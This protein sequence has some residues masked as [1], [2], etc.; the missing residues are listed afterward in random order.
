MSSEELLSFTVRPDRDALILKVSGDAD[1]G[2]A[3]RLDAALQALC[4]GEPA[5]FVVDFTG[6]RYFDSGALSALVRSARTCDDFGGEF[7]LVVRPRSNV[8]RIL[9]VA[10][11]NDY[12]RTYRS[13]DDALA[14]R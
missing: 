13:M 7:R 12:F 1:H 8:E 5:V 3:S 11:M 9:V 6:V 2:A 10:G 14:I 4:L